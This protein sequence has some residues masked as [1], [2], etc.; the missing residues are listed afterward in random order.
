MEEG[1]RVSS[2]ASSDNLSELSGAE[3]LMREAIELSRRVLPHPNPRVGSLVVSPEGD[4]VGRG[5]HHAAG[6]S[7][8]E[9]LA[10]LDAG[11]MALGATLVA[12]LEPCN[13]HG[14]MPP[15]TEAIIAAG[16]THVIVGAIDPD[17]RVGGSGVDRL[18][19]AG[20]RVTT[21]VA[22][23]E[24]IA[25]DRGYFHHR[26]TGQPR[27]VAKLAA[28]ID[29]QIAAADGTSQWI[30]GESAREDVHRLRSDVDAV[31]VGAGTLRV[32]DPL[33]TVRLDAYTGPQPRPV[34]LGGRR[35]LPEAA[36]LYERNPIVFV[37][38]STLVPASLGDVVRVPDPLVD[39]TAVIKELE[40]RGLLHVLV[41]G[42]GT[43]ARAFLDAGRL[44][45]AVIYLGGKLAG[46]QGSGMF[47]GK[48][49]TLVD[50]HDVVIESVKPLGT[51]IRIDVSFPVVSKEAA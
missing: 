2:R 21:G 30:T 50:A 51:D 35:P 4:V 29:G 23:D 26:R 36:K 3:A 17:A 42:G 19:A 46:G 33:L 12:T 41:E 48:F 6:S 18:R 43:V 16:I 49:A 13:H 9:P 20:I 14:R 24:V 37:P 47:A 38:D 22:R 11:E 15:C 10:L 25:S 31:V 27:V 39:P 34:V 7:H 8:A 44:D 32:D 40:S 1:G 5:Y 28:T 45:A